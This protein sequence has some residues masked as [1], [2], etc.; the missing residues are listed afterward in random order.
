MARC[1]VKNC[2]GTYIRKIVSY[3]NLCKVNTPEYN[4]S[5]EDYEKLDNKKGYHSVVSEHCNVCNDDLELRL[6]SFIH[7]NFK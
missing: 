2:D 3:S 5:I 4:L 6:I 7:N 1:E